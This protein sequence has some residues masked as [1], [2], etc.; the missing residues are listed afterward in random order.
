M[1]NQILHE[2]RESMRGKFDI[3]YM[4]RDMAR[5]FGAPDEEHNWLANVK[6]DDQFGLFDSSRTKLTLHQ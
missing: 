3:L 5:L 6:L 2:Q 4:I 1:K